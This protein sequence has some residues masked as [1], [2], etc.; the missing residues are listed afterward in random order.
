MLRAGPG[1]GRREVDAGSTVTLVVAE[2]PERGRRCPTS[3]AATSPRRSPRS[4]RRGL[5]V[6]VEERAVDRPSQDGVV[7]SPVAARRAQRLER[8]RRVTITV[9]RFEP[10]LD[11]DADD[12]DEDARADEP[13]RRRRPHDDR[14]R[15]P[16][17][18]R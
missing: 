3:P 8:G 5:E 16:G 12:A 4:R 14:T 6:N 18:A 9:G 11:P 15:R 13:A 17:T 7:Q 1:G 2:E 10:D